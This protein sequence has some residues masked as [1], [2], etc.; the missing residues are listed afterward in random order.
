MAG[1][2]LSS[3][4]DLTPT[5][6]EFKAFDK[7]LE[8][9]GRWAYFITQNRE[10]GEKKPYSLPDRYEAVAEIQLPPDVPEA[11]RS[12]FNTAKM[13]CVY[14]WLYYPLH[15]MAELKA[16]ATVELALGLRLPDLSKK[17]LKVLLTRA[18]AEGFVTDSGFTHIETD[19]QDPQRY[20]RMLPDLIPELRNTLA[21]GT[22]LLHPGSL[23][24]VRNCAEIV[25]QLF[26]KKE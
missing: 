1:A 15:P 13:L 17:G 3:A 6:E 22:P 24:T 8:P 18:V 11:V 19:K 26:Q 5:V 2:R 16:F 7:L 10:T 4:L 9:D 25:A 21:H 12:E 23:F 20:S 14:A